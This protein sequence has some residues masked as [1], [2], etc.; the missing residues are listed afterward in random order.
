MMPDETPWD[1]TCD[2][3]GYPN[4]LSEGD[5]LGNYDDEGDDDE[6]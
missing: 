1:Y 4:L 3:D 2:E 6:E 5:D